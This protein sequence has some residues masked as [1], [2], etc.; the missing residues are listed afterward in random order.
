MP[1]NVILETE[2]VYN[3]IRL[4]DK[5]R[6][7]YLTL[8]SQRGDL[9]QTGYVKEGTLINLSLV[10]LFNLGPVITPV[11]DLLVLGM[12]GGIS[13]LLSGNYASKVIVLKEKK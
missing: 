4:I 12:A 8:N 3:Q 10:D 5:D 7:I 1:S 6:M 11:K 9:A 2:S 13:V